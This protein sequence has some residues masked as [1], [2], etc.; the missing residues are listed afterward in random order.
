MSEE[1]A[2]ESLDDVLR[3]ADEGEPGIIPE[4]TGEPIPADQDTEDHND[5]G[6][7]D[8]GAPPAPEEPAKEPDAAKADDKQDFHVPGAALIAEREKRQAAERRYAEI[9]A[10]LR[11]LQQPGAKRPSVLDDEEGAFRHVSSELQ[12]Q[13][14]SELIGMRVEMSQEMMRAQH[15]DYDEAE[16]EFLKLAEANPLLRH[17]LATS[18]MPAQYVY[19]TVQQHRELAELKDTKTLRSK[20]E[21]EVRAEVEK[22]VRAELEES[23]KQEAA[24]RDAVMPS[25][26]KGGSD[27]AIER[28]EPESLEEILQ[29]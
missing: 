11:A 7:E 19:R 29:R 12:S 16:A 13:L 27:N 23:L 9:E 18:P 28:T 1:T 14:R 4:A 2:Y 24:K 15:P 26:A 25:L 21:A 6:D 10:Q 8:K 3:D 5:E 17:E 20:I 22:A